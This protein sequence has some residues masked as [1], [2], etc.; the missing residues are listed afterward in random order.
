MERWRGKHALVTGASAGIGFAIAEG[1][2]RA[3]VNVIGCARNPSTLEELGEKLPPGS[4]KIFSV[5]TDL[6]K[7][8]EISA[9]FHEI[10]TKWGHVDILVNNAG[11]GKMGSLESQSTED[12][13][14][15]FQLNV[16][17]TSICTRETLKLLE[18]DGIEDGHIININS[19][20]GHSNTALTI[21][22]IGFYSG[23]KHMI[24][25]ISK[26]LYTELAKKKSKIR[27]TSISPG[28][29]S[30]RVV[31]QYKEALGE[32]VKGT[33]LDAVLLE[34]KDISDAV[35][36]VVGSPPHVVI[37]ELTIVP[38]GQIY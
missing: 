13:Q 31:K 36:Y 27:V 5:K 16:L 38:S 3:G 24:T 9:L 6:E 33:A 15:I 20:A 32:N 14:Q 8:E 21:D 22:G 19:V 11:G 26:N 34:C 30:S 23:A 37:T 17:A 10:Q 29:V 35:L 12:W 7:E 2:A 1:L 25:A 28:I 18:K 4:G